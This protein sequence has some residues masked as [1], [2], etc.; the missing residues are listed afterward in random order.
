[1]GAGAL[2]SLVG[3][4]LARRDHDVHLVGRD[5]HVT[6]V[7]RDGLHITG[8]VTGSA[9]PTASRTSRP[10]DV[11]VV[12]VKSY[13]TETAAETIAGQQDTVV[14][15]QNGLG[16]ESEL[17]EAL[18]ATVLAG[19]ATYGARLTEPG[20]VECTGVGEIAIGAVEGGPSDDA[21]RFVRA[22]RDA[23][24]VRQSEAM[25][26]E[27]WQKLAVNA[28]I[29]PVTALTGMRNGPAA[30]AAEDVMR[31]AARETAAAARD[32]GVDAGKERDLADM[33][34]R[35]ARSTAENRSSMLQDVSA[36]RQTEIEAINGHVAAVADRPVPTNLT[37]AT[38]VRALRE[39]DHTPQGRQPDLGGEQPADPDA[40]GA[41]A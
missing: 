29:N 21:E 22:T 40:G 31:A 14:S 16:N 30:A 37:L 18:D 17:D 1:M 23:L 9:K 3:G 41:G 2:G 27:L 19:T 34:I 12:T 36:G 13:D 28:A 26:R 24:D 8:T 39:A 33:A 10:A 38:L 4:L 6:A 32:A 25:P 11:T 35:V 5:D 15:L 20:V 7:E